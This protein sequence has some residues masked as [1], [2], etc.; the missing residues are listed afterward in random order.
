MKSF[1]SIYEALDYAASLPDR[2][3]FPFTCR[4]E[5]GLRLKVISPE[6]ARTLEPGRPTLVATR[7]NTKGMVIGYL[8]SI[9]ALR[10]L[11]HHLATPTLRYSIVQWQEMVTVLLHGPRGVNASFDFS[12]VRRVDNLPAEEGTQVLLSPVDRGKDW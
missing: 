3:R 5:G 7:S 6:L 8:L 4:C 12:V 1:S 2:L 10:D 9:R 11:L